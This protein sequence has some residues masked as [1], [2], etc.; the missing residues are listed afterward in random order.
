MSLS[1]QTCRPSPAHL[2]RTTGC[3][4]TSHSVWVV[5]PQPARERPGIRTAKRDPDILVCQGKLV[6][7]VLLEGDYISQGLSTREVGQIGER[8]IRCWVTLSIVPADG[9]LEASGSEKRTHLCSKRKTSA[10]NLAAFLIIS[11]SVA[12]QAGLAGPSAPSIRK[13]GPLSGSQRVRLEKKRCCQVRVSD[14]EKWSSFC[15]NHCGSATSVPAGSGGAR[16]PTASF[17]VGGRAEA[18]RDNTST[19]KTARISSLQPLLCA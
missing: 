5:H 9:K 10:P 16:S 19:S 13:T 1:Q 8:G 12:S 2:D 3:H 7:D 14:S 6:H 18:D 15:W 17:L 11:V 4:G